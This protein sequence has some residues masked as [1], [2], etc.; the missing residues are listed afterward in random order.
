[1]YCV[2]VPAYMCNA[3]CLLNGVVLPSLCVLFNIG[4][5]LGMSA[6]LSDCRSRCL[7]KRTKT[8]MSMSKTHHSVQ[9]ELDTQTY[10]IYAREMLRHT[11]I[12]S[13]LCDVS[14]LH[15]NFDTIKNIPVG[16]V[17]PVYSAE[18]GTVYMRIIHDTLIFDTT[19]DHTLIH[20]N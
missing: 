2:G 7:V 3:H 5:H 10:T 12:T 1:M 17:A 13:Q 11:T 9:C 16:T 20:P 18:L 4:Q 15:S 14:G 8:D 19:M 6:T